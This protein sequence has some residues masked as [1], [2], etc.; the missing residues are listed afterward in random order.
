[1]GQANGEVSSSPDSDT[2]PKITAY[3]TVARQLRYSH[4]VGYRRLGHGALLVG[5]S[6]GHAARAVEPTADLHP[7][8]GTDQG[9]LHLMMI[10]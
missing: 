10:F 2:T 3:E 6:A 9:Q 4:S 5:Y 7:G 8:A 1:V